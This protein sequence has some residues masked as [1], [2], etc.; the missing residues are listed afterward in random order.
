[1]TKTWQSLLASEKPQAKWYRID[2]KN[3]DDPPAE[4]GLWSVTNPRYALELKGGVDL[5]PPQKDGQESA[6]K[7]E[8]KSF[9]A[10][11]EYIK[12]FDQKE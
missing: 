1:M 6:L 11:L 3:W 5:M 12:M 10:A 9:E 4:V 8:C 7:F 2:R